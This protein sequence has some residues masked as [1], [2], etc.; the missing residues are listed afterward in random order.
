MNKREKIIKAMGNK[1]F[2]VTFTKK[3]GTVRVMNARRGVKKGVTGVGLAYDAA[4]KGLITVYDMKKRQF[5]S[6]NV[7]T[8]QT[9]K[10]VG[11]THTF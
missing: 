4:E 10:T 11:I 6:V 9:V 2:T 7:D 5:R 1:I 3:D 8:V